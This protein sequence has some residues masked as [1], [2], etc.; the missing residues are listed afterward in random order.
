MTSFKQQA[1]GVLAAEMFMDSF[2][3]SQV[4]AEASDSPTVLAAKVANELLDVDGV[5]ASFV[6]TKVGDTVFVSARS[7]DDVNVQV[8]TERMG[9]GGHANVAGVQFTN[10]T[11]EEIIEKIK[12]LL[13]DMYQ[14]GDL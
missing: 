14:Q 11:V 10:A 12:S 6:L 1:E 9:G 8:I 5:R 3:I 4:D 13:T 7:V 2:A